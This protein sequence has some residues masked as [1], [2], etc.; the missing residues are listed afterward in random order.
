MLGSEC[1]RDGLKVSTAP[2]FFFFLFKDFGLFTYFSFGCAGSSLLLEL[3]S[4][5]GKR[6]LLSSCAA[7][8]SHC[9]GFSFGGT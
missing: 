9:G 4:G 6:G 7:W 8:A 1:I 3:F 2:F 5:C